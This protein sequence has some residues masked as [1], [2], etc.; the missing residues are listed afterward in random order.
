MLSLGR[1]SKNTD[2]ASTATTN[3]TMR[4][5]GSGLWGSAGTHLHPSLANGCLTQKLSGIQLN[6]RYC[7]PYPK[8][9]IEL[10]KEKPTSTC[11]LFL[12]L[13]LKGWVIR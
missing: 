11:L 9:E 6:Q 5:G 1:E 12:S 10:Q 13:V 2:L 4:T 7:V 8:G 3:R